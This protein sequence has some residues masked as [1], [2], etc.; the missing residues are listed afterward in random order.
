MTCPQCGSDNLRFGF[1]ALDGG[2]HYTKSGVIDVTTC[3]DLEYD[4]D[5]ECCDC[6]HE[7]EGTPE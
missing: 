2:W 4:G 6:H 3:G 1:N 7:W 5:A